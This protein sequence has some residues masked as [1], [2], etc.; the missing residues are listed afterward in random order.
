M[1][2]VHSRQKSLNRVG[3]SSESHAIVRAITDLARSLK[4]R[5][6]AEGVETE[7]QL[8]QVRLLGCTEMQGYLL[9]P[10]RPAAEIS[11]FFT[12]RADYADNLI[13]LNASA[14][15]NWTLTKVGH[16]CD[17]TSKLE[18]KCFWCQYGHLMSILRVI[19]NNL[20]N[21]GAGAG[22]MERQR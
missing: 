13:A 20:S 5:V 4:L 16:L 14:D 7:Q 10:P 18:I 19:P 6:T 2:P 3:D 15:R 11:Q 21:V 22:P 17:Q 9:S 8:Q 1:G 12:P